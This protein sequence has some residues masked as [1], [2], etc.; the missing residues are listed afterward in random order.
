M[1]LARYLLKRSVILV[2]TL[3][4]AV[5]ITIVLV[6]ASMDD[7]LKTSIK[8]DCIEQADKLKFPTPEARARWIKECI[9]AGMGKAGFQP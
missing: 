8:R 3:F 4:A 1:I 6:G 7:A 5:L 2:G 9:E